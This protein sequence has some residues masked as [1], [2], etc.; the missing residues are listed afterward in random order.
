MGFA[1]AVAVKTQRVIIGLGIIEMALH[2]PMQLAIQTAF[3][4]N[5][6]RAPLKVVTAFVDRAVN[7]LLHLVP[8]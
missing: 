8:A 5:L 2:N 7:R 4:D 1:A 6:S 3:L